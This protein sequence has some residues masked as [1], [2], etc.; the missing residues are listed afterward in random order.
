MLGF[1]HTG[2]TL[3]RVLERAKVPFR[4]L[5]LHPERV[6]RGRQKGLPIEFGDATNDRDLKHA[7]IERARAV[8]ILLSDPRA[9]RRVVSLCRGLGRGLFVLARTRYLAEVSDLSALGADEGISVK[10]K[11]VNKFTEDT[12]LTNSGKRITYEY[13]V[14]IQNNKRTSERVIVADQVPLSRNEKLAPLAGD[15]AGALRTH[16]MIDVDDAGSIGRRYRRQDEAGTPFGITVDGQS[17]Q[18]GT[19]TVRDRD[20]LLQERVAADRLVTYLSEKLSG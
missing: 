8:L 4:I 2:E 18:D 10:H 12:G 3:A 16:F 13:L 14:T 17:T 1:G 7:G 9:T 20:T 6:A 19:V 11:R 5:D 15:V